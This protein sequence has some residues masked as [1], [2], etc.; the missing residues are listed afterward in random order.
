[1]PIPCPAMANY[2]AATG[3]VGQPLKQKSAM[4]LFPLAFTIICFLIFVIPMYLLLYIVHNPVASYWINL[5]SVFILLIPFIILTVHFIH[6]SIGG[7]N[8]FAILVA[9][10]VPS[11]ILILSAN[12]AMTKSLDFATM[13]FSVD[14][15]TLAAKAE[16]QRSWEDAAALYGKCIEET[17]ASRNL[18]ESYLAANFRVQDCTEYPDALKKN[19]K[20]WNYLRLLEETQFCTGFC[21]SGTR[22]WGH[23]VAKDSCSVAISSMF[24]NLVHAHSAQVMLMMLVVLLSTFIAMI[25]VGPVMREHNIPW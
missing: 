13:L 17:A 6:V 12:I 11:V 2:G 14:C 3:L 22:L 8:K 16:L 18:T 25:L 5:R 10:V 15:N 19:A 9:L 20:T 24:R 23:G 21:T 1:L 7:P 4:Q